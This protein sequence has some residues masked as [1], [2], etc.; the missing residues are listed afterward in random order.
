M[1]QSFIN[2]NT[3]LVQNENNLIFVGMMNKVGRP[4]VRELP[5]RLDNAYF[6]AV[7]SRDEWKEKTC[8]AKRQL[9][10]EKLNN[11]RSK[12]REQLLKDENAKLQERIKVLENNTNAFE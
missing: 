1:S 3:C 4:G 2:K 11:K 10:N 6:T 8:E 7:Q 12:E 9:N 5:D